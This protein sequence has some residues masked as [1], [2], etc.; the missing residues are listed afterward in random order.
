MDHA[1]RIVERVVED[2]EPRMTC[3]LE[4]LYQF[5]ERDVL[6]DRDDVGARNHHVVDP[7]FAQPKNI[8]EHRAFFRRE[9]EIAGGAV[10]QNLLEVG[11]RRSRAPAEHRAQPLREEP[12]AAVARPGTATVDRKIASGTLWL[13][14]RLAARDAAG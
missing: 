7:P 3:I 2:D 8:L 12:V 1:D 13:G 9:A 6:L 4:H 11:A 10:L 14:R 5:A